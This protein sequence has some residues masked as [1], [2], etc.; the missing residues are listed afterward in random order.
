DP[1]AAPRALRE[2]DSRTF[3]EYLRDLER[4]CRPGVAYAA[5]VRAGD[6]VVGFAVVWVRAQ[7]FWQTL[8]DG[9]GKAGPHSHAALLDR[10]GVR[11]GHSASRRAFFSP[12]GDL[13]GRARQA[14]ADARR[15]GQGTQA[16]L[17][18]VQPFRDAFARATAAE[19][20]GGRVFR[21]LEQ[22][23]GAWD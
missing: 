15:F 6:A 8:R 13:D 12:A 20:P 19:D 22:A 1:W 9:D 16:L 18:D 21:G 5:P 4:E 23:T 7:A 11:I 3:D 17:D 14:M 2:D 10:A